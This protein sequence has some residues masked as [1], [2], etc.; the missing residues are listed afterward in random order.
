MNPSILMTK[1]YWLNTVFSVAR[2]YGGIRIMGHEYI[3]TKA[4]DLL[5]GDF[6]KYYRK[7]GRDRFIE[8]LRYHQRDSDFGLK[9]IFKEEVEKMKTE[10]KEKGKEQSLF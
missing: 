4:G 9:E 3:I 2:F 8:I 6:L 5:R 7:L 1:E 10:K